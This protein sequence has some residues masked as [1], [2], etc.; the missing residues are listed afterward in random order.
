MDC[1]TPVAL[2]PRCLQGLC[3]SL[4]A[5]QLHQ[6]TPTAPALVLRHSPSCLADGV[7]FQGLRFPTA[8]AQSPAPGQSPLN[9]SG[10]RTLRA[11]SRSLQQ[12]FCH[13]K[14]LPSYSQ[15]P[16]PAGEQDQAPQGPLRR[17]GEPSLATSPSSPHRP[18][19]P[20]WAALTQPCSGDNA[21]GMLWHCWTVGLS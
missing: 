9:S 5:R 17:S 20:T 4:H 19:C 3:S 13:Q 6:A 12:T 18:H 10:S 1:P 11:E 2:S 8:C 14:Y 15:L 7:L 16:A 21:P